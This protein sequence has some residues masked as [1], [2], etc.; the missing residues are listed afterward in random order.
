M[1]KEKT[2]SEEEKTLKHI[3]CMNYENCKNKLY[4]E[5]NHHRLCNQCRKKTL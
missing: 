2:T 1:D 5:G 4:S 3:K